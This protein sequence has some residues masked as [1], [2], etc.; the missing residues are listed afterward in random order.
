MDV[1]QNGQ[2]IS[3]T[4]PDGQQTT[5]ASYIAQPIPP[6]IATGQLVGFVNIPPGT[7]GSSSPPASKAD[8]PAQRKSLAL[9]GATQSPLGPSPAAAKKR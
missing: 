1:F 2:R 9:P 7:P 3:F 8:K 6:A 5:S 4:G